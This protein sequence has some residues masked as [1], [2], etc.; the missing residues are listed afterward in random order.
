MANATRTP[1]HKVY[2][3]RDRG[4]GRKASWTEIGVG[5]VNRDGSVNLALN[6]VPLDGRVQLRKIEERREKGTKG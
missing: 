5:F 4:E 3:I 2:W 6:L 1:S